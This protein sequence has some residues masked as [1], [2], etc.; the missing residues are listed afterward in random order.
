[1]LKSDIYVDFLTLEEQIKYLKSLDLIIENK[2]FALNLLKTVPYYDLINGYS[3]FFMKNGKFKEG[4]TLI[5]LFEFYLFDKNIQTILFKYSLNIENFFKTQLSYLISEKIGVEV[6]QYTNPKN[7]T[8]ITYS[9]KR[10]DKLFE[11]L[12]AIK[13]QAQNNIDNP[14]K[15]Y[16]NNYKNIP[17]WILFKN[18]N[19]NTTY[20]LFTFLKKE[21]KIELINNYYDSNLLTVNEN[22]DLFKKALTIVRKFRNRIAHNLKVISYRCEKGLTHPNLLKVLDEKELINNN[23]NLN[24]SINDLYSM[25]LSEILLLNHSHFKASL[26]YEMRFLFRSNPEIA[27][28]YFEIANFPSDTLTRIEKLIERKANNL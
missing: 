18:L 23:M 24:I 9:K 21:D 25:F 19:F 12:N 2:E 17:S 26:L 8:K 28:K 5:F 27:L 7:Y 15:H 20:D 11:T 10:K 1:M 4:I 13:Y 16:R 22:I 6:S 14:T 3:N